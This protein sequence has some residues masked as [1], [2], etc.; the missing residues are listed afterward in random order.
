MQPW[1]CAKCGH[2]FTDRE[3]KCEDWRVKEKS[4]ICP[5][6]NTPLKKVKESPKDALVFFAQIIGLI[7]FINLIPKNAG[8][9]V[10]A[11]FSFTWLGLIIWMSYHRGRLSVLRP[12]LEHGRTEVISHPKDS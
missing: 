6:C 10:Q 12:K 3:V 9:F 1:K 2:L 4:F 7:F 5:S 11:L 8:V